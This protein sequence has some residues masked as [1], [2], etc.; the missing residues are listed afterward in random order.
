MQFYAQGIS[1]LW[2]I[3]TKMETIQETAQFM[4]STCPERTGEK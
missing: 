1:A 3:P 2:L 4:F